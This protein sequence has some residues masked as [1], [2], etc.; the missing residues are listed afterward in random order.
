[1]ARSSSLHSYSRLDVQVGVN[2]IA[3]LFAPEQIDSWSGLYR[4]TW[5]GGRKSVGSKVIRTSE[6]D[7]NPDSYFIF[8]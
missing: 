3:T 4:V 7:S 6:L 1:M 2:H 5:L 8:L